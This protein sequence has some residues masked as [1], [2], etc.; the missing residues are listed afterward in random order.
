MGFLERTY[1]GR[2]KIWKEPT[3]VERKYGKN[4]QW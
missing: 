3:M 1:N 2:K 4:L